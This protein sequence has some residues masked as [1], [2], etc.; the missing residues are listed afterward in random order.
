MDDYNMITIGL[1]VLQSVGFISL[2][3][4]AL[5]G[6]LFVLDKLIPKRPKMI[7]VLVTLTIFL[8][9]ITAVYQTIY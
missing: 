4:M 6:S 5:I 8:L 7:M 2:G 1:K 9:T 3:L